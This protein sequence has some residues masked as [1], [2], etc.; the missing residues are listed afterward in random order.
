MTLPSKITKIISKIPEKYAV[1]RKI[2]EKNYQGLNLDELESL[3]LKKKEFDTEL[4]A[5]I[6]VKVLSSNSK[7]LELLKYLSVLNTKIETNIDPKSVQK[8]YKKRLFNIMKQRV[9]ILKKIIIML[10]K[11]YDI[12]QK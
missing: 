11:F 7:A 1:L 8:A 6:V 2:L 10:Q 5:S 4:Y 9:T 12:N 3:I